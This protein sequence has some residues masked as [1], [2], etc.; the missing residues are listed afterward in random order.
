MSPR[1][2]G[3]LALFIANLGGGGAQRTMVR[4]ANHFALS[5]H[6]VDLLTAEDGGVLRH[7]VDP[8]VRLRS[9]ENRWTRLPG[10]AGVKR[11]RMLAA[12]L[13]LARYLDAER[14][15][16]LLSSSD[17]VNVAAILAA[18]VARVATRVVLRVDNPVSRSPKVRGSWAQRRRMRRVRRLFPR[19]DR[20]IAIS[21]GVGDD[22]LAQGGCARS[23]QVVIHNPS[24]DSELTKRASGAPG[25]PWLEGPGPPVVLG[26]GRLVPQKDFP[27]LLRAFARV[28]AHREARLVILGDGRERG[29][30][31]AEARSLGIAKDF[32]LAGFHPNPAAAMARASV[33]VLSSAWE[34]FGNVLVEAMA[35]GCPVV[36]CDCP[37]GPGEILAGGRY[38]RLVPVGDD[39]ALSRAILETLVAPGD[40]DRARLR[41][42]EFCIDQIAERY[43]EVLLG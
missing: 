41:A 40:V 38:G 28:R 11:R 30:L 1:D 12:T 19:A 7:R 17:S 43:L 13:P 29:H 6:Q 33:F 15:Q 8:R 24:L 5:G 32:D 25:H 10:I 16:A 39:E 21:H 20:I 37:S 2:P 18:R 14:P 27:T 35:V 3:H 34:G 36:S 31:E 26:V 9:L 42:Q 22:L 4:L 23:Q